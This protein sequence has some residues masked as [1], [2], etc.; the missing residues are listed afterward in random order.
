M[1]KYKRAN[2]THAVA[3]ILPWSGA[4]LN[5]AATCAFAAAIYTADV[6]SVNCEMH[7]SRHSSGPRFLNYTGVT[8]WIRP[9]L[10]L[11]WGEK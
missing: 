8:T 11:Q 9:R 2:D 5:T 7:A 10:L 4:K 1:D 6:H 3:S